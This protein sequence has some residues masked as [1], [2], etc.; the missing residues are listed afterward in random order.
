MRVHL[1]LT[2]VERLESAI[3]LGFAEFAEEQ[4]GRVNQE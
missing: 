1:L 4:D 3:D 2:R